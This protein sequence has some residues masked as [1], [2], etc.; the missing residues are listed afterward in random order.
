MMKSKSP[1]GGPNSAETAAR[2]MG[3][4]THVRGGSI[5]A[6]ERRAMGGRYQVTSDRGDGLPLPA[7]RAPEPHGGHY[8]RA[9]DF[10][11][12]SHV[13]GYDKGLAPGYD[14]TLEKEGKKDE[15]G[16][17]E[18]REWTPPGKEARC[19]LI[20]RT[21]NDGALAMVGIYAVDP[22]GNVVKVPPD[23]LV[24]KAGWKWAAVSDIN[25][26]NSGEEDRRKQDEERRKQAEK[27]PPAPPP[28]QHVPF[29]TE[30]PEQRQAR[31]DA[32]PVLK[33]EREGRAPSDAERLLDSNRR[34]D[35]QPQRSQAQPP[36]A[37]KDDAK[38]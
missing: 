18:I 16:M 3:G 34:G 22:Q 25:E 19:V 20:N 4:T 35:T 5:A 32:D 11:K 21:H 33:A 26:K 23:T 30:T 36:A 29:S 24:L 9:D 10:E 28:A 17:Y 12:Y 27:Q 13:I 15:R 2:V 8:F 31:E 7:D 38:K 14:P 1:D 6:A 37:H